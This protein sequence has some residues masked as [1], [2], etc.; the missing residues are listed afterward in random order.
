MVKS[1]SFEPFHLFFL[2]PFFILF[3]AELID[4][5]REKERERLRESKRDIER[6]WEKE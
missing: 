5:E 3:H 2:F 1:S 6:H 4:R